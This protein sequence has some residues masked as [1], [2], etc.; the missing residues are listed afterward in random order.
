MEQLNISVGR[1]TPNPCDHEWDTV[2]TSAQAEQ[3]WEEEELRL[4]ITEEKRLKCEK[5]GTTTNKSEKLRK[6]RIET[7]TIETY[8]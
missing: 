6:V 3:L 7:E 8:K 2:S 5:C 4:L 1:N